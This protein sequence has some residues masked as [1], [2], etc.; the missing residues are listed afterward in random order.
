MDGIRFDGTGPEGAELGSIFI[1]CMHDP[2]EL[3]CPVC[4]GK[5]FSNCDG[6]GFA[7]EVCGVG[8]HVFPDKKN[9]RVLI[10]VQGA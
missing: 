7:C 9:C 5:V 4:G 8:I 6:D 1:E 3:R 2:Y 10:E